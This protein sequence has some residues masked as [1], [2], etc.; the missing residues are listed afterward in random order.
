MTN[1]LSIAAMGLVA[2]QKR[3]ISSGS[4]FDY[5]FAAPTYKD[6]IVHPTM[7]VAKTVL[8]MS[9]I[10]RDHK[11]ETE[12]IAN[13]LYTPDV[14]QFARN[15]WNF[16][17]GH[18][19]YELDKNGV[20]QLRTP[21]RTWAD[22]KEG[23]DCDCMSIFVSSILTNKQIPHIFRITK[24]GKPNWQHVY[25]VIPTEDGEIIIDTVMDSFNAQK[26]Y[27]DKW[28]FAAHT[29]KPLQSIGNLESEYE[30]QKPSISMLTWMKAN[31]VTSAAIGILA[32]SAGY[33]VYDTMKKKK[34]SQLTGRK[35]TTTRKKA[36]SKKLK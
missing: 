28:D 5:M 31:P 25:V 36:A 23:V 8:L 27:S 3:T 4:E 20:E 33:V 14:K 10:V 34:P 35:T 9:K 19:Q 2:S 18:I 1:P 17:Y 13:H 29:G 24:Y 7:D 15:I 11:H 12:L 26:E 22:R 16:V 32:A 6:P 30:P 21:Y